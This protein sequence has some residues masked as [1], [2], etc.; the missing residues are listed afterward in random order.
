MEVNYES[1]MSRLIEN[2]KKYF[3]IAISKT[4][5]NHFFCTLCKSNI[6][7]PNDNKNIK[8]HLKTRKHLN[9]LIRV[10]SFQAPSEEMPAKI[11]Y[12]DKEIKMQPD[13]SSAND[14]DDEE[15]KS[16]STSEFE[17]NDFNKISKELANLKKA[18]EQQQLSL[19]LL[20]NELKQNYLNYHKN[21]LEEFEY[22]VCFKGTVTFKK[23]KKKRKI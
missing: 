16:R 3:G 8:R 17:N 14:N 15:K 6:F 9:S 7:Y 10:H 4:E 1:K 2:K 12:D 13:L 5:S 11:E 22:D 21:D 18:F 23:K 20:Q 19:S